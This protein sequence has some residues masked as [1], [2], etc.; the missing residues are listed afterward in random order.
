MSVTR[1]I[2]LTF[3]LA[4]IAAAGFA[5]GVALERT[6]M[7]PYDTL[8]TA[9]RSARSAVR[10]APSYQPGRWRPY[11]SDHAERM[12]TE[13]Q[14]AEIERLEALAYVSGSKPAPE[15]SGVTVY[16]PELSWAGLNLVVSGHAPWAGLMHMDGHIVHDWQYSFRDVWPDHPISDEAVGTHHWRYVHLFEN[17][18][19]LAIFDGVGLIKLDA[20]SNLLWSRRGGFHHQLRVTPEGSI[21]ILDERAHV[22]PEWS[23]EQPLL[24]NY[25]TTL[26]SNGN[27]MRRVSLLDAFEGSPYSSTL[28]WAIAGGDPFHS[29]SIQLLDGVLSDRVPAFAAGNVLVSIRELDTIAVIDPDAE[30]IVWEMS[31]LWHRQ[32]DATLLPNGRMLVFD[33]LHAPGE[34]EVLEIDPFSEVVGWSYAGTED[35]P[36]YSETCGACQR[37]PN[38]NT[39]I[40]ESD[41]GRAFEV[42]ED[43]TLVWEYVNPHRAGENGELIA[44]LFDV[45]RLP[46]DFPTDWIE[47]AGR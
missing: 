38:G 8:L 15:R 25:V 36:F 9:Y 40:V 37:L 13:E 35:D 1:R 20:G 42:T 10:P 21:W 18:D 2:G 45:V 46:K 26:D 24:E 44:T 32:H 5:Y 30:S 29:N 22:V 14:R 31:G 17:G 16:D 7:F 39:L 4:A 47:D 3:M 23:E 34:S 6:R 43:G 41:N 11:R 28:K 27:V 12:L 19:I 33:N